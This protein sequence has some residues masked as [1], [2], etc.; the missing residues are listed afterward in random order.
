MWVMWYHVFHCSGTAR[1]V[2]DSVAMPLPAALPLLRDVPALAETMCL[3]RGS[4]V[5]AVYLAPQFTFQASFHNVIKSSFSV[6][7]LVYT[8][9]TGIMA[10]KTNFTDHCFV[11]WQCIKRSSCSDAAVIE[12]MYKY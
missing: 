5:T 6:S 11:G 12:K 1:L 3:P 7:G 8:T 9:I 4:L 2:P 10:Y